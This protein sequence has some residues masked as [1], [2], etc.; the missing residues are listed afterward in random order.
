MIRMA[1]PS[2]PC[3]PAG[4]PARLQKEMVKTNAASS[5]FFTGY[6]YLPRTAPPAADTGI[7]LWL[8]PDL[9]RSALFLRRRHNGAHCRAENTKTEM[10]V[11]SCFHVAGESGCGRY[12]LNSG[13][14]CCVP[15]PECRTKKELPQMRSS[16]CHSQL[17]LCYRRIRSPGCV[18]C[19]AKSVF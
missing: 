6:M 8:P 15:A 16:I 14:F 19:H 1:K 17:N 2:G 9:V 13:F 5:M 12:F 3:P 18:Y 10:Q 7:C 4:T 11:P